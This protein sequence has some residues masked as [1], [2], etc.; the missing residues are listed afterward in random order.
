MIGNRHDEMNRRFFLR[1]MIVKRLEEMTVC[2]PPNIL[3][4]RIIIRRTVK[5]IEPL[6]ERQ[7]LD[8]IPF[9]IAPIP[10]LHTIAQALKLRCHRSEIHLPKTLRL[11]IQIHADIAEA[12]DKPRDCHER[13]RTI[14]HKRLRIKSSLFGNQA[15]DA[16]GAMKIG[17]LGEHRPLRIRFAKDDEDMLRL[18]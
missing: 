2:R 13:K 7:F 3:L 8:G 11:I 10:K 1:Q 4:R 15:F 12:R 17:I 5:C 16:I 9:R 18:R 6:G 14:W